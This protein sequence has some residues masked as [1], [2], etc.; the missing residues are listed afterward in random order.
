LTNIIKAYK[1]KNLI[2][3][4]IV[5]A[6]LIAASNTYAQKFSHYYSRTLYDGVQNPH[7]RS[8][9][10]CS[11]WG[12]SAFFLPLPSFGLDIAVEGGVND[13]GKAYIAGENLSDFPLPGDKSSRIN[14]Y[15][16]MNL[17]VLKIRTSK[18]M[19][20]EVFLSSQLRTEAGLTFGNNFFNFITQ[21][22]QPYLEDNS[23]DGFLNID[24]TVQAYHTLSLGYRQ[25]I[26]DKLSGGFKVGYITGAA[27]VDLDIEHSNLRTRS[28][29]NG[30]DMEVTIQGKI[31][32]SI[33]RN[34]T[35]ENGDIDVSQLQDQYM[36]NR[37]FAFSGGLQYQLTPKAT[38][39][40]AVLDLGSITW[41]NK[42]KTYS[43]NKTIVF[44]GVN[45][46]DSAD[47]RER[48]L[49]SLINFAVDSSTGSYTTPLYSKLELTGNYKW[50]KWFNNTAIISKQLYRPDLD[51]VLLH[52]FRLARSINFIFI[53]G[54]NTVNDVNIGAE[55]LFR[56][57]GV[58]F[59][60]GSERLF[61][62]YQATKQLEDRKNKNDYPI[63][64]DFNFG[65][66]YRFGRCPKNMV[67]TEGPKDSDADGV[68]DALDQCPYIS[69]PRENKGCPFADTDADGLL[70]TADACPTVRGVIDNKGCPWPD[71]DNDGVFDK[72][73]LCPSAA[74][75][76]E[77][78]GCPD[79]DKDSVLDKDDACPTVPGP[80]DNLGCPYIDTDNDSIPDKFDECPVSP[81][82]VSN[83][84][85]PK[86]AELTQQEQEVINKVFSNLNFQTGKA[87][88]AKSSYASLDALYKLLITKPNFKVLIEGH[89]DNVG[90]RQSNIR[91]S[92][93]RAKA[94][95]DYLVK[96]GI[97]EER[98]VDKGYG[99]D[100]PVAD[101]KTAAGK[102]KNRR[103]EFTVLE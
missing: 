79:A 26:Y 49:D 59:Y 16:N 81:G 4:L 72:D 52:N 103:V 56:S 64:V 58:D 98:L 11:S 29:A 89:T 17:F 70:D 18:R 31:R 100:R 77:T 47:V 68:I 85:C 34:D 20:G 5:A 92:E 101:N 57:R 86:K 13:L 55:F 41:H 63:G 65:M 83:K 30:G 82:P 61:N 76:V 12:I 48:T 90:N 80:V 96:K 28:I 43:L 33:D 67:K 25:K 50:A 91:L 19:Q 21:G 75:P 84:G 40:L 46:M 3:F 74:G 93:A 27:N 10:S 45:A 66:A 32:T 6:L 97:E 37:G 102:A 8:L 15:V 95:K 23:L 1:M 24:G 14:P 94:V 99:P 88:I 73:D 71:S 2:K 36:N 42:S 60:L 69:G 62:T 38:L 9:D 78:R 53:T 54:Y 87:I 44:S 35:T 7:H 22:N 51:I 39:G